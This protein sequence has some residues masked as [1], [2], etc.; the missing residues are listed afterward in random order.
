MKPS[1]RESAQKIAL[2]PR[3]GTGF[4]VYELQHTTFGLGLLTGR[5]PSRL[6]PTPSAQNKPLVLDIRAAQTSL[7]NAVFLPR[8]H[9]IQYFVK[10]VSPDLS[11]LFLRLC[12]HFDGWGLL[13]RNHAR[14]MARMNPSVHLRDNLAPQFCAENPLPNWPHI[15]MHKLAD[16]VIPHAARLQ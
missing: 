10:R 9:T 6:T 7:C 8:R 11:L 16:R 2:A 1:M 12:A 14:A 4:H 15:H 3:M 13:P 5:T